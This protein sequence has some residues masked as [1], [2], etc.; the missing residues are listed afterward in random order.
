MFV[1]RP[2]QVRPGKLH[3]AEAF[4]TA[5]A[6]RGWSLSSSKR[7]RMSSMSFC[8]SGGI[9]ASTSCIDLVDAYQN[10]DRLIGEPGPVRHEHF[11]TLLDDGAIAAFEVF[12][13]LGCKPDAGHDVNGEVDQMRKIRIKL[14]KLIFVEL[15]AAGDR[16]SLTFCIS[17]A[18]RP[19]TAS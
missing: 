16:S 8:F 9:L 1:R 6:I 18:P 5:P 2:R 11:K 7:W 13:A 19:G 10:A 17:D 4:A 3:E 12:G 15:R 14:D